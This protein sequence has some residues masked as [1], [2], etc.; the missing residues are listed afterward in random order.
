MDLYMIEIMLSNYSKDHFR[1][2][3]NI[4]ELIH[5]VSLRANY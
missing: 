1:K 3:S 2:I 5:C 4:N